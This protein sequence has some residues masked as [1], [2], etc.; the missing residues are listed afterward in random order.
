MFRVQQRVAQDDFYRIYVLKQDAVDTYLACNLFG[1]FWSREG[2]IWVRD[3]GLPLIE[4]H[5]SLEG[6]VTENEAVQAT[7]LFSPVCWDKL[8]DLM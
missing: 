3:D 8:M 5:I 1:L 2:E 6:G 4:Q 7:G